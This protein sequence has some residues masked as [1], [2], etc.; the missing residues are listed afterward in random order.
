V[1][2]SNRNDMHSATI[3]TQPIRWLEHWRSTRSIR[4]L[5]V[6]RCELC[7]HVSRVSNDA[8]AKCSLEDLPTTITFLFTA[9]TALTR[10]F[11]YCVSGAH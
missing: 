6:R 5:L 2:V 9:A 3:L 7:R 11:L 1:F 10:S 8:T 4:G